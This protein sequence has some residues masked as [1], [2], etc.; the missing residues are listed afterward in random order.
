MGV[1]LRLVPGEARLFFE[2]EDLEDTLF[3]LGSGE[4]AIYSR[5][6]PTKLSP[7][8]DAAAVL[9]TGENAVVLAVADGLGGA[10]AGQQ[11][12][13]IAVEC[14]V[15]AVRDA[16]EAGREVRAGILDGFERANE[17][18]LRLGLGA[19]TTLTVAE[20]QAGSV[21]AYHAGDS[22]VLLV[23]NRG[24]LKMQTIS[25]SPVGYGVEAGLLDERAAM[26]HEERHVISNVI[27]SSDMRIDVGTPQSLARRD[28]L[29]LASDGLSDNL[30]TG[31]IV[32]R[33]R[34]GPL[35]KV[36][37]SL[38]EVAW[39]RMESGGEDGTPSKPDDLTFLVFRLRT[40]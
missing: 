39:S 6:S 21:R 2:Q 14:L 9:T 26:Y 29:V 15:Q 19:G 8:E 3:A 31:E 25:H 12:S 32:E 34:R 17:E 28:T 1:T 10:P 13:A 16:A 40:S 35:A 30:H 5:R 22:F 37:R 23:G 20:V 24:K 36:A 27:G 33:V 18:V 4:V 38:A 7:N 11:A